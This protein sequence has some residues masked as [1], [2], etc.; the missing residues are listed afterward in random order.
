MNTP[1]AHVI[2]E[3]ESERGWRYDVTVTLNGDTSVHSVTLDWSDHDHWSGGAT[4]PS[5][6]VLAVVSVAVRELGPDR[7]PSAFDA[8]TLRRLLP[9]LDVLVKESIG[10]TED[11]D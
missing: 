2:T 8:S 4:P 9:D 7:L 6:V 5:E 11:G 1:I 10:W 3:Y